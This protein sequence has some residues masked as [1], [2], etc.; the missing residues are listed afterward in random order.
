MQAHKNDAPSRNP[1]TGT[2]SLHKPR[3][4]LLPGYTRM[5]PLAVVVNCLLSLRGKSWHNPHTLPAA[6]LVHCLGW[7][8]AI[9]LTPHRPLYTVYRTASAPRSCSLL[10]VLHPAP[11]APSAIQGRGCCSE[12]VAAGCCFAFWLRRLPSWHRASARA[13]TSI[14][15]SIIV[16]SVVAGASTPTKG[17]SASA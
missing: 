5:L 15:A 11:R 4:I 3:S 10:R 12:A 1:R 9:S 14:Q 8:P 16:A 13:S 17:A 6:R 7:T 2:T